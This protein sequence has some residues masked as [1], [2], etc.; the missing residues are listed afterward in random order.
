MFP[1]GNF[2]SKHT[3]GRPGLK[4]QVLKLR[5]LDDEQNKA[6]VRGLKE[7]TALHGWFICQY[8]KENIFNWIEGYMDPA[9]CTARGKFY[10]ESKAC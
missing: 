7:Y 5:T 9:G 8:T 1:A 6:F 2:S 3:K 10:L 4:E